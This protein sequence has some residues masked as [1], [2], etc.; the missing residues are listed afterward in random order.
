LGFKGSPFFLYGIK[1]EH[2]KK[3]SLG[4][5]IIITWC[6]TLYIIF[7]FSIFLLI[8]QVPYYSWINDSYHLN[9]KFYNRYL[10][11]L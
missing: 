9:K 7:H 5:I 11:F 1:K 4:G 10:S 8:P 6:N 3:S 2:Y